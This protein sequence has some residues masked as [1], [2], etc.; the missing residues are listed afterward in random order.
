MLL[1]LWLPATVHC[2]LETIPDLGFLRCRHYSESAPHQDPDCQKDGC[3]VVESGAYRIE[4]NP[5][6]ELPVPVVLALPVTDLLMPEL[7]AEPFLPAIAASPPDLSARWQIVLR[8]ALSPRAPS[9][10]T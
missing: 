4:D 3:V 10:L 1:V 7:Q 9:K 5:S 2:L 8:A 6:F